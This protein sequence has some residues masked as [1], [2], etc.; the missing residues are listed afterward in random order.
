VGGGSKGKV[1]KQPQTSQKQLFPFVD[2]HKSQ[3]ENTKKKIGKI[4]VPTLP[5]NQNQKPK[6]SKIIN[7]SVAQTN[8]LQGQRERKK[9]VVLDL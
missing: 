6:T 1:G 9:K 4:I 2:F 3:P 8:V 7:S 5:K